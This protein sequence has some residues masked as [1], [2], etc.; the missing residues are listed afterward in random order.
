MTILSVMISVS[1]S[2]IV[3]APIN[4]HLLIMEEHT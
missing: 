3:Y 4:V 1:N 2:S